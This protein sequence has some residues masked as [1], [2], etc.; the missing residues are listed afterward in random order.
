MGGGAGRIVVNPGLPNK[1]DLNPLSDGNTLIKEDILRIETG[2]GGG[3]GHPFDRSTKA[4]L[5]DVL[6]GYVSA[7]AATRLYGVVVT[8]RHIDGV[9]TTR[10]RTARPEVKAFHRKE[11]TDVLD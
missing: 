4:V 9:E 5:N 8:G 6:G 3:H 1:R 10:L 11:Y 7:E 2:G